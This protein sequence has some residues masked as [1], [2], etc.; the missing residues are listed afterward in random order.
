VLARLDVFRTITTGMPDWKALQAGH[1][2]PGLLA[3]GRARGH[4]TTGVR[5]VWVS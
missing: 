5:L 3:G 4:A 2:Q 1:D